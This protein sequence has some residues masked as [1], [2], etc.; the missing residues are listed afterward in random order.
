MMNSMCINGNITRLRRYMYSERGGIVVGARPLC[1]AAAHNRLEI[2][3]VLIK[4]HRVDVNQA[5]QDGSNPFIIAALNGHLTLLRC[6]VY[7]LGADVNKADN[8]GSTALFFACR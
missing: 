6:L 1:Y 2:L 7:E 8:V 3:R 5:L 4:G